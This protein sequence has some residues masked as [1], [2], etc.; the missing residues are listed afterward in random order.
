MFGLRPE[1]RRLEAAAGSCPDGGKFHRVSEDLIVRLQADGELQ[2]SG[3]FGWDL[4][5]MGTL[6]ERF[7]MADPEHYVLRSL[8]AAVA[9]GASYFRLDQGALTT[10]LTW[11][12]LLPGPTELADLSPLAGPSRL[13]ELAMALL[14]A[15]RLGR[16]KFSLVEG[17]ARLVLVRAGWRNLFNRGRSRKLLSDR[18]R[19]APLRLEP[20]IAP[21]LF[22]S[23]TESPLI[24]VRWGTGETVVVKD[25]VSFWA[26]SVPG[27]DIVWWRDDLQLALS[28]D[29]LVLG[30]EFWAAWDE[31]LESLLPLLVRPDCPSRLVQWALK[32]ACKHPALQPLPLFA[33]SSGK[34]ATLAELTEQYGREGYL[35]VRSS[36]GP[37]AAVM[38]DPVCGEFLEE[39]FPNRLPVDQVSR[40]FARLPEGE[41]YALRWPVLDWEV[42]FRRRPAREFRWRAN[43]AW[44][45]LRM[46]PFGLDSANSKSPPL[47]LL[48]VGIRALFNTREAT[49]P[50]L[51]FQVLSYLCEVAQ[52]DGRRDGDSLHRHLQ[53]SG[54][55]PLLHGT[56]FFLRRGGTVTLERLMEERGEWLIYEAC[57][58]RGLLVDFLVAELLTELLTPDFRCF[59][60]EGRRFSRACQSALQEPDPIE[61]IL[62]NPGC[63]GHR[64]W[65]RAEVNPVVETRT[66]ETA[67]AGL[68]EVLGDSQRAATTA[69]LL[70]ALGFDELATEL[71]E[72]GELE[73]LQDLE[74]DEAHFVGELRVVWLSEVAECLARSGKLEA[75][76]ERAQE[77]VRNFP[78]NWQSWYLL[79]NV[80]AWLGELGLAEQCYRKS[81]RMEGT[82]RY[83]R[84]YPE[85]LWASGQTEAARNLLSGDRLMRARLEEDEDE[86]LR[87]CLELLSEPGCPLSVHERL[88]QVYAGL[89][90]DEEARAHFLLF[91]QARPDQ[92]LEA[93]LVARREAAVDWLLRK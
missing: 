39:H 6:L 76:L 57:G 78:E 51:Q 66:V 54:D 12:G 15:S 77:C 88:G 29:S 52:L 20:E 48:A 2:S 13:S 56:Q 36:P 37:P 40:D 27:L 62:S 31:A 85:L 42:G 86:S 17:E 11:D 9:G 41:V 14:T 75:A 90:R 35:P 63:A 25:G 46:Q 72:W 91:V 45:T 83:D 8:A 30:P 93:N 65:K 28:R 7:Q 68:N 92:L 67:L 26:P 22:E 49:D 18:G 61:S 70:A 79:G 43:N 32:N 71:V 59:R 80:R 55:L 60:S 53:Q 21:V 34:W 23:L 58:G 38:M 10:R 24:K 74:E 3:R 89:G 33:L 87:L 47:E 5:R 1:L 50:L 64:M 16:V 44:I 19:Y 84:R 81:S 82:P 73:N 4:G 69:H